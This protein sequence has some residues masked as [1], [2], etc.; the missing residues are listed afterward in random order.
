[1]KSEVIVYRVYKGDSKDCED[2]AYESKDIED[3]IDYAERH[4]GDTV[5]AT[6]M[7]VVLAYE[8]GKY[9]SAFDE[10]LV[11][12][13]QSTYE[14]AKITRVENV[15]EAK[16]VYLGENCYVLVVLSDIGEGW[17]DFWM[18]IDPYGY[19]VSLG[20]DGSYM[21]SFKADSWSDALEVVERWSV[22][23]FEKRVRK[24]QESSMGMRSHAD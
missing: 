4:F 5:G 8:D 21:G 15:P 24:I 6:V 22:E 10:D 9:E 11:W 23:H 14:R 13:S 12:E 20:Y 19:N 7:K 18:M 3:A 2:Y 16:K 1:M 17:Y